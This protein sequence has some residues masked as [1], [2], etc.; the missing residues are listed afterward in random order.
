VTFLLHHLA[1]EAAGQPAAD[2]FIALFVQPRMSAEFEDGAAC[3]PSG[4]APGVGNGVDDLVAAILAR[5]GVVSTAP[6]AVK[7]GG[8]DGQL[9]DLRLAAS[10]TRGCVAPEGP[11]VGIPILHQAGSEPAPLV[12]L[13]RDHPVRL[14]LLDLTGG[15]TLAIA[16]F[17]PEPSQP[18]VFEAHAAEVMPI[19]ESFEFAAPTP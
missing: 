2:T 16:I 1:D 9:L 19:I 18:S 13:A 15:R 10:W 4:E 7:I 17:E 6:T 14:I 3:R 11:I 12:G 5:P 8:Y